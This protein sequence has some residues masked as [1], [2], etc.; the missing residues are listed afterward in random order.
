[1][2]DH[3]GVRFDQLGKDSEIVVVDNRL[4]FFRQQGT[5]NALDMLA[6]LI[7]LFGRSDAQPF[8]IDKEKVFLRL[9]SETFGKG[10]REQVFFKAHGLRTKNPG[11]H[12]QEFFSHQRREFHFLQDVFLQ[13]D[14]G[15]DLDEHQSL[16][17]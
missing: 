6:D 9:V 5:A 13:V 16:L 10:Q 7:D 11:I 4:D 17:A 15:R 12:H 2:I 1:V 14:A 3:G 8:K